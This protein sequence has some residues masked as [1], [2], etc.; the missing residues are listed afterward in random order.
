[1]RLTDRITL[2]TSALRD[3][4]TRTLLSILGITIGI[5]AVIVVGTISKG[6]NDKI[7]A[8]L[9]TFGLKTIWIYRNYN[10]KDPNQ[11]V[12]AGTG[13]SKQDYAL[14]KAHCCTAVKRISP[15]IRLHN[16]HILHNGNHYSNANVKGVN[17]DFMSIAND[18][19]IRGRGLRQQDMIKRRA[20][21]ILSPTAAHDLFAKSDP[22]GKEITLGNRK[23]VVIGIL[24]KKSRDFLASIGSAGGDDPNNRILIPYTFAM[25]LNGNS[26]IDYFRAEAN[27]LEQAELASEQVKAFLS[28]I[29]HKKYNY[30][31]QTMAGYIKNANNILN[32][33]A[34]IGIIA[35]SVSLLVGGMGIMNMMSTAVL[36]RTREIGLRKAIGATERD[37]LLQFLLESIIISLLGGILGLVIGWG[38]SLLLATLV[39]FPAIPATL[40]TGLALSVAIIVGLISG[41]LPAKRAAAK[42][43]VEALRY[44]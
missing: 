22:L 34:M 14:L 28:R 11:Q 26:Q 12:R 7:F 9:Q 2:A 39:G 41:Y 31:S 17:S 3:N 29:Q 1:M 37:I 36:E 10:D 16:T 19:L 13:I 8:E 24:K 15:V 44:E 20:V 43:P 21:A 23:L 18:T 33:V 4:R 38:M 27:T 42:P 35:A 32:G 6:G 30:K 25:Q 5:I 40:S